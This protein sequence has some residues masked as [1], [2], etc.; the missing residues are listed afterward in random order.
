MSSINFKG[1]IEKLNIEKTNRERIVA[2]LLVLSFIVV[3][4]VAYLLRKPGVTIAGDLIS[5]CGHE[6]HV[7]GESCYELICTLSDEEIDASDDEESDVEAVFEAASAH[8]HNDKCYVLICELEEHTHDDYC[9]ADYSADIEY[10]MEWEQ[11]IAGLTLSDNIR[12]NIVAIA[13]SQIGYTESTRNFVVDEALVKHGYTRYGEWYGGNGFRYVDWSA[14]FASFCLFYAQDNSVEFNSGDNL[15]LMNSSVSGIKREAEQ[16]GVFHAYGSGYEA[17]VGDMLVFSVTDENGFVTEYV[18]V[19]TYAFANTLSCVAGDIDNMVSEFY[20][21]TV[22]PG[23][24]SIIGFIEIVKAEEETEE[25]SF[26]DDITDGTDGGD[27]TDSTGETAGEPNIEIDNAEIDTDDTDITEGD[28]ENSTVESDDEATESDGI[29]EDFEEDESNNEVG[30][31][32]S[33]ENEENDGMESVINPALLMAMPV[34]SSDITTSSVVTSLFTASSYPVSALANISESEYDRTIPID[35]GKRRYRIISIAEL[36][37][38]IGENT[39][40]VIVL[41]RDAFQ[42]TY[43]A[44]GEGSISSMVNVSTL[45]VTRGSWEYYSATGADWSGDYITISTAAIAAFNEGDTITIGYEINGITGNPQLQVYHGGWSD[46]TVLILNGCETWGGINIEQGSTSVSF[47]L[48]KEQADMI[49]SNIDE[50]DNILYIKGP[51]VTIKNVQVTTLAVV[52]DVESNSIDLFKW[53]IRDAGNGAY[54][55]YNAE[56]GRPASLYTQLTTDTFNAGNAANGNYNGRYLLY[57]NLLPTAPSDSL[58]TNADGNDVAVF[59][60]DGIH[61]YWVGMPQL[62]SK[63]TYNNYVFSTAIK[64]TNGGYGASI[65]MGLP[66]DEGLDLYEEVT[67]DGDLIGVTGIQLAISPTAV[68]IGVINAHKDANPFSTA[69]IPLTN[70]DFS[71]DFVDVKVVSNGN[72]MTI[73]VGGQYVAK[74]VFDE[75]SIADV[76]MQVNGNRT[77]YDTVRC[78]T[79]GTIYTVNDQKVEFSGKAVAIGGLVGISMRGGQGLVV[80]SMSMAEIT[81]DDKLLYPNFNTNLVSCALNTI[82]GGAEWYDYNPGSGYFATYNNVGADVADQFYFAVEEIEYEEYVHTLKYAAEN[83]EMHVFNYGAAINDMYPNFPFYSEFSYGNSVDGVN[84]CMTSSEYYGESGREEIPLNVFT[85]RKFDTGRILGDDGYPTVTSNTYADAPVYSL[86][87]LFNKLSTFVPGIVSN[88]EIYNVESFY[89][90]DPADFDMKWFY[91]NHVKNPYTNEAFNSA[92]T[93]YHNV[94]TY[95]S[96][97]ENPNYVSQHFEVLNP[98]VDD[99]TGNQEGTGLFRI[100]ERGFYYYD[101]AETAAYYNQFTGKFE[102]YDYTIIPNDFNVSQAELHGNFLPFNQGHTQGTLIPTGSYDSG[103]VDE[104]RYRLSAFTDYVDP[105]RSGNEYDTETMRDCWFGMTMELDFYMPKGGQVKLPNSEEKI[106]MQ[107]NFSGDDDVLVY[108]DDVLVLDISGT[109][110]EFDGYINFQ[111]GEVAYAQSGPTGDGSNTNKIITNIKA[112]YML[113]LESIQASDPDKAAELEQYITINF[114]DDSNTFRNYSKH[115]LKFFYL[116]RGGNVSNASISFNVSPLPVGD[117]V[118]QKLITDVNGEVVDDVEEYNNK[119]YEFRVTDSDGGVLNYVVYNFFE[120]TDDKYPDART[121]D[122][123]GNFK[124]KNGEIAY[125][126]AVADAQT[127]FTVEEINPGDDIY[128]TSYTVNSEDAYISEVG[129]KTDPFGLGEDPVDVIFRNI[130]KVSLSF[131]K[132]LEGDEVVAGDYD[133]SFEFEGSHTQPDGI[134]EDSLFHFSLIPQKPTDNE[135]TINSKKVILSD[136]PLGSKVTI[137]ELSAD[138]YSVVVKNNTDGTNSSGNIYTFTIGPQITELTYVN[139]KGVRLPT[140]GGSGNAKTVMY[141]GAGIILLTFICRYS[142]RRK[143]GGGVDIITLDLR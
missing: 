103:G 22:N 30:N 40:S 57:K 118:V 13:K 63:T 38:H 92:H 3:M 120:S 43:H 141:I 140:T 94:A 6:A 64:K 12:S 27:E 106:P 28:S 48:T 76:A 56:T 71:T 122:A 114:A 83:I 123:N 16:M 61:F 136:I 54:H 62:L 36:N 117:I 34:D 21:D 55:F 74:I 134:D 73:I 66:N 14:M 39:E 52:A 139:T 104:T 77:T 107:F 47:T 110:P 2:V 135:A 8:T 130:P 124:L 67:G 59:D 33:E 32:D 26:S 113:A 29:T 90:N 82:V 125:F 137:R 81:A 17:E 4:I 23:N 37:Q 142:L 41:T 5:D 98:V 109:H 91:P 79:A 72:V 100:D 69:S 24:N 46:P 18:G 19:I 131:S 108:I 115:T 9:Y 102:L 58:I 49:N 70:V 35:T 127:Q 97:V 105:D 45:P 44:L 15:D 88:K 101:S 95:Y 42:D 132:R 68:K 89:N 85:Y 80:N 138:G 119:E 53:D 78:Y 60:N 11:E 20:L 1:Y 112:Q 31:D 84:S 87:Y 121:T 99:S 129:T 75:N 111:T 65:F 128:S 86:N 96:P 126:K 116:E 50:W 143:K 51:G 25:P 93:T 7:H 10:N 133:F